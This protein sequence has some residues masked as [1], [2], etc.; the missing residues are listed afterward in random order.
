[1]TT[2]SALL[3]TALAIAD[4][5]PPQ[6]VSYDQ[7]GKDWAPECI[8]RCCEKYIGIPYSEGNP[9]IGRSL[10]CEG[11]EPGSPTQGYN[12]CRRLCVISEI[13]TRP[14]NQSQ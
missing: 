10:C 13:V 7:A 3:I 5:S 1:M 14:S 12:D 11:L 2:F 4:A 6:C 9:E 8:A